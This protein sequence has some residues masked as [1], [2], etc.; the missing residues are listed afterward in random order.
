MYCVKCRKKTETTDIEETTSKNNRKMLRGKCAVCGT[1]K[2]QFIKGS[3]IIN[4][5]INNLPFEMHLP[6]YNFL[7]PGT[8]LN[9]RL[10]P[11]LT[12][13]E[14]S[15]PINRVDEAA[16]NHDICYLKNKDTKTRNKVCDK[17]MLQD[18]NIL[19]PSIRERIDKS[20][21]G[22]IIRAKMAIGMGA[23]S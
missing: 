19:N 4:K 18:L 10:N 5:A 2:T 9:K 16:M 3:G 11:D 21:V 20:I 14:S 13:K 17:K 8:K 1:T 22:N 12:P 7:G 6:G 23:N 15:L